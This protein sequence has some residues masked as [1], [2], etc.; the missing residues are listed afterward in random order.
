M[1]G[2]QLSYVTVCNNCY[3]TILITGASKGYGYS[4]PQLVGF[5]GVELK[6]DV[7]CGQKYILSWLAVEFRDDW[8]T[9][10]IQSVETSSCQ[11]GCTPPGNGRC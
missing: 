1:R 11:L 10:T 9:C 5:Q 8:V 6:S 3:L 2:Q 4:G 7:Y